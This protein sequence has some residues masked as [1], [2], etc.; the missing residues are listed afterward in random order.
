MSIYSVEIKDKNKKLEYY[1]TVFPRL[2]KFYE[3]NYKTVEINKAKANKYDALV[4]KIKNT[5]K[6][7]NIK[8]KEELKGTKGQDIYYIKQKYMYQRNILQELIPEEE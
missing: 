6:E 2:N 7:L 8:E 1:E 4:E 3:N 5:I